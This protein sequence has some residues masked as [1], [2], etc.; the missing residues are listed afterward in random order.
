MSVPVPGSLFALFHT[1]SIGTRRI[2]AKLKH[3]RI[4][5]RRADR[6]SDEATL[7][8]GEGVLI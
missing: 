8:E 1:G 3:L 7:D 2:I 6:R 5:E 4:N